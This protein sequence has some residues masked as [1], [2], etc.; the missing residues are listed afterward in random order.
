[1]KSILL[2]FALVFATTVYATETKKACVTQTDAKTK[3]AKEV[4]KTVKV[5]KKLETAK[6]PVTPVPVAAASAP[7]APAKAK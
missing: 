1:M 3:Q 2:A 4:C 7:V 6:A 5:H